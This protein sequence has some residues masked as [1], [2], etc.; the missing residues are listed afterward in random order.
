MNQYWYVIKPKSIHDSDLF[1]FYLSSFLSSR[2]PSSIPHY[3]LWSHLIGLAV[4][5]VRLPLYLMT[6]TAL[7]VM[8]NYFVECLSIG[9]CLMFF[10]W[11]VWLQVFERRITE[12]IL[13]MSN[14]WYILSRWLFPVDAGLDYLVETGFVMFLHCELT[15]LP[16][17]LTVTLSKEVT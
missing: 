5:V 10:L 2:I 9:I 11:S 15:L 16:S 14:Q 12:A 3:M 4:T 7:R 8:V 17:F 1:S 6:L 13:I